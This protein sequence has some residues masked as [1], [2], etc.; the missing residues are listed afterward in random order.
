MSRTDRAAR[1]R[2]CL[3]TR[4]AISFDRLQAEL[5][6]S[7]ATLTR[8]IA[9]LRSVMGAPVEF[10]RERGGYILKPEQYGGTQ[11]ELS[12]WFSS[13]EIH[14]LLT[15]QHLLANLDEGGI[16]TR[17][18]Q[19]LMERLNALLGAAKDDAEAAAC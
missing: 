8:D 10:D 13:A 17:H 4:T 18:V 14:A 2:Q 3:S 6:V 11:L 12:I 5:E 19:P 1:I 9:Y 7:R 16:L 15:M